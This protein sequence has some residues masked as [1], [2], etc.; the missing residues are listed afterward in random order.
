M[1]TLIGHSI[2]ALPINSLILNRKNSLKMTLVAVLCSI[3]PDIDIIGFNYGIRYASL[4]GHRGFT[5]SISF[6]VLIGIT[7]AIFIVLLDKQPN[8]KES[9]SIVAS[10]T[11]ITLSHSCLDAMTDGGL[12]CAF[13]SPFSNERYFLPWRPFKVA[14]IGLHSFLIYEGKSILLEELAYLVL[15][16]LTILTYNLARLGLQNRKKKV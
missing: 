13:F 16:S 14:A 9:V 5:H 6:A 1:P 10:F 7:V 3:L 8:L 11:L 4:F 15:P 2:I 12:G